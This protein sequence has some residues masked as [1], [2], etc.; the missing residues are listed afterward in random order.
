MPLLVLRVLLYPFL[1]SYVD[2]KA[3]FWGE[4]M[5]RNLSQAGQVSR[6]EE[7]SPASLSQWN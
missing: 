6:E 4:D 5:Q 3:V 1:V 7:S 2:S